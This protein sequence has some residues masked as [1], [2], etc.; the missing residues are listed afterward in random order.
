MCILLLFISLWKFVVSLLSVVHSSFFFDLPSS[1][2]IDE[3]SFFYSFLFFCFL[4]FLFDYYVFVVYWSLFLKFL[5][6]IFCLFIKFFFSQR[7]KRRVFRL[8]SFDCGFQSVGV[9]MIEIEHFG[10][11]IVGYWLEVWLKYFFHV[12][13]SL[14]REYH[15]ICFSTIPLCLD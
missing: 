8:I 9:S 7:R 12:T 2:S 4:F 15:S 6:F 3:L 1:N 11:L 5:N 10:V 13:M 14:F